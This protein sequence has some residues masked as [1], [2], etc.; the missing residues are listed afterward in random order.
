M[1]HILALKIGYHPNNLHLQLASIWPSAFSGMKPEFVGYIE[2]RE[3][4]QRLWKGEFDISGTGS[5]PP[6]LAA[7]S[8]LSVR[9]A[10]ASAP[11][12]ANGAILVSPSSGI[13]TVADLKGKPVALVDGSFLTYFLA[14]RLEEVGLRLTDV[15]RRD[16]LP[17]ASRDALRDGTVAAWIAMAPHLEQSLVNDTFRILSHCGNL[18]PNR[19]TFW[20]V[21]DRGLSRETLN[22]FAH[23]LE[24]LGHEIAADPEKAAALLS[25]SGEEAQ[26][27]AWTRIVSERNW[28]T[29][30]A[31]EH[32]IREQQA[33]AD[34][35]FAHGD[36]A[37]RLIIETNNGKGSRA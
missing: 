18:I 30:A 10:A 23:A 20:T 4:A 19:S 1:R 13:N 15:E 28:Q 32:L 16:I 22:E 8:G 21:Q 3:T 12:P 26:R 5:T 11:R 37:E 31:D 25:S 7:A 14:K 17:V 2:G 34:T 29:N 33:E 36:L 27:R 24:Q 6:V 9:Y 35:L